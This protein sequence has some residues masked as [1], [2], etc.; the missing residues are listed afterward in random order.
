M[1]EV[2]ERAGH[3]GDAG[4]H[5]A[6]VG[7]PLGKVDRLVVHGE[8]DIAEHGQAEAGRGDDDV[9]LEHVAGTQPDPAL[10]EGLDVSV[11]ARGV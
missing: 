11:T 7:D 6:A 2:A 10:G 4:D 1:P 3:V 8:R 5:D 9:R